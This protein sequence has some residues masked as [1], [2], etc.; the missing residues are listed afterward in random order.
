MR[1]AGIWRCRSREAP[2]LIV[3]CTIAGAPWG[4]DAELHIVTYNPWFELV[5]GDGVTVTCG[6]QN[7]Q[8]EQPEQGGGEGAEEGEGQDGQED[9]AEGEWTEESQ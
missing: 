1:G 5:N 7:P 9:Q 4:P 2:G 8:P 3:Q 6:E